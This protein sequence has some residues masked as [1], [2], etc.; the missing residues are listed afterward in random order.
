M[1]A[2]SEGEPN[3]FKES[4]YRYHEFLKADPYNPTGLQEE[5]RTL[6]TAMSTD[7]VYKGPKGLMV[8]SFM[9]DLG[10][11][12][13]ERNGD[14]ETARTLRDVMHTSSYFAEHSGNGLLISEA[15]LIAVTASPILPGK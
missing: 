2:G 10:A 1:Q 13:A 7:P 4:F 15:S 9:A 5:L 11:D 6:N 12:V 14:P 8:I 3:P